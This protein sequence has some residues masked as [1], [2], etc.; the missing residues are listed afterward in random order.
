[1]ME[2]NSPVDRIEADPLP[3]RGSSK[4]RMP[5]AHAITSGSTKKR[6]EIGK[7]LRVGLSSVCGG[8]ALA[9]LIFTAGSVKYAIIPVMISRMPRLWKVPENPM[10]ATINAPAAGETTE[11]RV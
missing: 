5:C 1:M 4:K 9:A 6:H 11:A 2:N 8:G 7:K 3:L 10:P